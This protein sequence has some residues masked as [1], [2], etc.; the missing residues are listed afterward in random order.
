MKNEN[1]KEI[2]EY[3][4]NKNNKK[5]ESKNQKPKDTKG[6][7]FI[8]VIIILIAL[9][10]IYYLYTSGFDFPLTQNNDKTTTITIDSGSQTILES[11]KDYIIYCNKKGIYAVNKR[12]ELEWN[13]PMTLN[14]PFLYTNKKSILVGD[15]GGKEVNIVTNYATIDPIK[16]NEPIITAKINATGYF[17]IVTDEKGY[18]GKLTVYNPK[19]QEIYR[20][21]SVKNNIIDVDISND[22]EKIA[23][24]VLN[25]SKGIVSS[26]LIFFY[27][28]DEAPYAA[29]EIE[30]TLITNIKFYKNNSLIAF[31]DNQVMGFSP[32]GVKKWNIGF[33]DKEISAY[34][35]DSDHIIAIAFESEKSSL[36]DSKSIVEIFNRDGSKIGEYESNGKINRLVVKDR[37]IA[38]YQNRKIHII[39]TK[40]E[41]IAN[42]SSNKDI[43]NIIL[44]EEKGKILVISRNEL[45]I[46]EY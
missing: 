33:T 29:A 24:S 38:F 28:G 34:N 25:T 35:I 7:I 20:W 41:E 36:L 46:L 4:R 15:R 13:V 23:V 44:L 21:H 30:D 2:K 8:G 18:K 45:D 40:G 22:G 39:N 1:V 11:Y 37:Q 3:R 31:G 14:S 6:S 16:T 9:G 27:V 17:A 12:G 19:G 32:Q 26:G 5:S 43:K 10:G 42:L